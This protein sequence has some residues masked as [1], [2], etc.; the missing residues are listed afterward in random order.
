M[1]NFT[2]TRASAG[3]KIKVLV[4]APAG[5]GKTRLCG[6]TPDP[7]RTLIISAESGLLSLADVEIPVFEIKKIQDLDQIYDY[8]CTDEAKRQFDWICLDSVTE[9]AEQVL[10]AA[11][12]VSSDPRQAYG[13][14]IDEMTVALKGFR[15]L[16]YNVYMSCKQERIKDEAEGL[17][18]YSP[19]M[20][21]SK[22]AQNVPYL[23]D[24]VFALHVHR[25]INSETG[26]VKISRML[27]TQ[28]DSRYSAKDRSGA[29]SLWEEPNLALIA[30]KIQDRISGLDSK[31]DL[32]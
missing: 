6:T 2:T 3:Q 21:G 10:A 13:K 7:Q 11:K 25:E 22:L 17:T 5:S 15:E 14:L 1:M 29:L 8:L 24:E 26:E 4:H 18:L 20:P 19:S 27:Q 23:F 32:D 16:P 12:E 30:K 28:S 31:K 9:I